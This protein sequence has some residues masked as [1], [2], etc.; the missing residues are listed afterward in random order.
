MAKMDADLRVYSSSKHFEKEREVGNEV[1]GFK[2]NSL[3]FSL[4]Q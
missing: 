3:T 4:R 2:K 1:V